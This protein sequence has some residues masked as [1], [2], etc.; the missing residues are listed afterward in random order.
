VTSLATAGLI[1]VVV[2]PSG[3]LGALFDNPVMNWIGTR[4][5]GIYLWHWPIFMLTRPGFEVADAPVA[6]FVLRTAATFAFAEVSYRLVE[7]PI[8]KLG[9]RG[10]LD[11]IGT[12]GRRLTTRS[13]LLGAAVVA[14]LLVLGIGPQLIDGSASASSPEDISAAALPTTTIGETASTPA[15]E[16]PVTKVVDAPTL[17]LSAAV[18]SDPQDPSSTSASEGTTSTAPQPTAPPAPD[19]DPPADVASP[20]TSADLSSGV[21]HLSLEP[22]DATP[23][24][25]TLIGDSIL[26]GSSNAIFGTF[27]NPVTI[28]ATVSRQFGQ[29]AAVALE[30]ADKQALGDIGIIHLGTTGAFRG[31]TFDTVMEAVSSAKRVIVLTTAVPR[32]WEDSVN[33]AIR[34]GAERWPDIEILDWQAIATANSDWFKDDRV[35]LNATGQQAYA[36]LLAATVNG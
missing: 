4:S 15:S 14:S 30:L 6:V 25:V 11:S 36:E 12:T 28:D 5:Y 27:V 8:R 10:W 13:A 3:K 19:V 33:T 18:A 7:T 22:V 35:H 34:Q 16:A 31:A 24:T 29:A 17:S 21:S 2:H 32:R 1:A 20:G 23:L 9:F 26:A